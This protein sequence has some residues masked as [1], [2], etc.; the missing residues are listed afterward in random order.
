MK[1]VLQPHQRCK[2]MAASDCC[3]VS[4]SY[5]SR[6]IPVS[7]FVHPSLLLFSSFYRSRFQKRKQYG[8]IRKHCG[9][10][11]RTIGGAREDHGR[12]EG[13]P[14]KE[15]HD[16]LSYDDADEHAEGIDRGVADGGGIAPQRVVGIAEGHG[17]GHASAEDATDGAKIKL[18]GAQ[19]YQP[20]DDDGDEGEDKA[21]SHPKQALGSHDGVEKSL[22]SIKA[23]AGEVKAQTQFAEH[24]RSRPRRVADDVE[25]R[26]EGSHKNTHHDRA[27]RRAKA[28]RGVHAGKADGQHADGEAKEHADKDTA[29]VGL[30]ERLDRIAKE[31]LGM[32][33]RVGTADDSDM[34]AIL[35]SQV[36]GSQELDVTTGD[37]AHVDAIGV[38][39]MKLPEF[40][41]VEG[42]AREDKGAA[43][44]VGVDVVPVDL[45]LVP[46]LLHLLAEEH[47]HSRL[48]LFAGHDQDIV[49]RIE[50]CTCQRYHGLSLAPN[51]RDDK[52]G[53]CG[54]G[55]LGQRPPLQGWIDHHV[56]SHKGMVL[57]ALMT[58]RKSVV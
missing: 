51:A 9:F 34:V 52:L 25:A 18:L 49:A 1:Q 35:Q 5:R 54:A 33:Q 6:I 28:D 40:A 10:D 23:E 37:A 15:H 26:R 45:R 4:V 8:T 58:D 55:Y 57:V 30:V 22:A 21:H 41:A 36:V 48:R 31:V 53:L 27:T 47:L 2:K 3:H 11:T 17:I 46:V 14:D 20:N 7:S 16:D 38:A 13:L 44:D 19:G 56:L 32:L 50:L 43:L 42:R 24:E 29:E 12:S 39:Q